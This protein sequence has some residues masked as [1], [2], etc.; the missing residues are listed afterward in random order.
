METSNA[1]IFYCL[2]FF[3]TGQAWGARVRVNHSPQNNDKTIEDVEPILDVIEESF[4]KNLQDHF[5]GKKS[6]KEE[7]ATFK[8]HR[9]RRRLNNI[10]KSIN[11]NGLWVSY[12]KSSFNSCESNL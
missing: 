2:E 1:I 5:N 7:I 12:F 4:S 9:Q 6:T 8:H 10:N 11:S 3:F